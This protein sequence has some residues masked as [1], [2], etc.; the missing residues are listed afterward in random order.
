MKKIFTF[1]LITIGI[2]C[3][4]SYAQEKIEIFFQQ[5][6]SIPVKETNIRLAGHSAKQ[7]QQVKKIKKAYQEKKI[8]VEKNNG[9]TSQQK[10][11]RLD[12]LE[13]EKEEKLQAILTR[14]QKEKMKKYKNNTPRRGVT[15]MPNERTSR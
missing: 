14:E 8:S 12:K 7:E 4:E 1:I 3:F 11:S 2:S 9:L 13:K 15:N 10:K 5:D 6:S